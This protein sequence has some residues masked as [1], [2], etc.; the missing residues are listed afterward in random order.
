MELKPYQQKVLGDLQE[1]LDRLQ[2]YPN[3]QKAF[4]EFWTERVGSSEDLVKILPRYQSQGIMAPRVCIKVPTGGGKTFIAS[5]AIST[6]FQFIKLK[7]KFVLWLVPGRTILEQT[8]R[9]LSDTNHPYRQKINFH[10][11]NK[12]QVYSKEQV[13]QG[14]NFSPTKV[15][16]Q[17]SILVM[18]FD[19]FRARD[20]DSRKIYEANGQLDGFS[21]HFGQDVEDLSEIDSS[22]LMNVI[23]K[24]SPVVMVDESH[25]TGSELSLE[26][27]QNINPSFILDLTA[28]PRKTANI[29]SAVHAGELKSV[30]MIKL[31]LIAYNHKSKVDVLNN[32]IQMQRKLEKFAKEEEKETGK[33]IR[34]IV[35]FQAQPNKNEDSEHFQKIKAK[36]LEMKIPEE[37]IKIKTSGIDEIKGVNLLSKSCPVRYIITVDA[38]KE[39]WDCPFAYILASLAERNSPVAVEQIVGRT[40]RQPYAV[41]HKIDVLNMAYV[42]TSSEKFMQTLEDIKKSMRIAGFE[43]DDV[44]AEEVEFSLTQE[45]SKT[46]QGVF[47]FDSASSDMSIQ[48]IPADIINNSDESSIEEILEV[49]KKHNEKFQEDIKNENKYG[50]VNANLPKEIRE[51]L[52]EISMKKEFKDK[53][54]EVKLPRFF[55]NAEMGLFATEKVPFSKENILQKFQLSKCDTNISFEE[56]GADIYKF[57]L[58]EDYSVKY[59]RLKMDEVNRFKSLFQ[60]LTSKESKVRELTAK[61]KEILGK[62]N[63][64]EEKEIEKYLTRVFESLSEEQ[65]QDC[66]DKQYFYR[67]RIKA[68]IDKLSS[69]HAEKVFEKDL[70]SN[71]IYLQE[72]YQIPFVQPN[73]DVEPTGIT[74]SLYPKEYKMNELEK[75][76]INE[77]ANIDNVLLWTKNPERKGFFINGFINHYPD[78]LVVLHSG[79]ILALE[80]KGDHLDNS[81]SEHKLHLGKLWAD[82]AG[83]KFRYLMVFENQ[84]LKGSYSIASA[85][86]IVRSL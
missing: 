68:K 85:K 26:M 47:S 49:A 81:D 30:N 12:V 31:P 14:A 22:A 34:P 59:A 17:L 56:A 63:Y 74:K 16:D 44:R 57:D 33:Y 36:L 46:K 7:P 53:I 41:S 50:Y 77:I 54:I 38:L 20:K 8:I 86:D 40:L 28:T 72:D 76:V 9:A 42:F 55:V 21:T 51:K 84:E 79:R 18:S 6:I 73:G 24:M 32:A 80:T 61:M 82:K 83:D 11:Q 65:F 19:S 37:Q 45:S 10:F 58:D 5:N 27:L 35:L 52:P 43:E 48:D 3:P 15:K 2:M 78:F 66:I 64:I 67:D 25:N 62:L 4:S 69:E 75:K 13:L 71:K 29:I 60:S 23:R 70:L 39:G 1:F